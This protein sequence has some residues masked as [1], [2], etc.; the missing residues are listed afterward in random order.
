MAAEAVQE[1]GTTIPK[2]VKR[3]PA[4][5]KVLI[6]KVGQGAEAKWESVELM[7][8]KHE[9][10]L[11]KV[12]DKV[13]QHAR[14]GRAYEYRSLLKRAGRA[15]VHVDQEADLAAVVQAAGSKHVHLYVRPKADAAAAASSK[16]RNAPVSAAAKP[17]KEK[18]N[19]A[20][21]SGSNGAAGQTERGKAFVTRARPPL[22]NRPFLAP[23]RGNAPTFL[24]DAAF[25]GGAEVWPSGRA[26]P[27][28]PALP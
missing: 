14:V 2:L 12:Q 1:D 10:S 20:G 27:L 24:F 6:T 23:A 22:A 19:L 4:P 5:V 26:K 3:Q 7:F 15:F 8:A 13:K 9:V 18:Q 28:M 17:K 11:R 21:G 16:P 25:S